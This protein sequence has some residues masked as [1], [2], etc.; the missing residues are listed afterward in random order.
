MQKHSSEKD[1]QHFQESANKI[2]SKIGYSNNKNI[3]ADTEI[4]SE[5]LGSDS[6]LILVVSFMTGEL[7]RAFQSGFLLFL[8]FLVVDIVVAAVLSSLGMQMVQPTTISLPL[9]LTLFVQSDGWRLLI[10]GLIN[11]YS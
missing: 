6:P 1:R 9:K 3:F 10:D 4:N 5:I 2:W 8:P 11:S 7:S